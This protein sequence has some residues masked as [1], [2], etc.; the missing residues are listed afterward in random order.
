MRKLTSTEL[1][2]NRLYATIETA[3]FQDYEVIGHVK[4][5]LLI[6]DKEND[7]DVVI[8]AIVKKSKVDFTKEQIERPTEQV[9][10]E[11]DKDKE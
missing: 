3:E 9:K 8:K 10:D 5:G 4:Q 1:K 7:I 2:R 11:D 6:R